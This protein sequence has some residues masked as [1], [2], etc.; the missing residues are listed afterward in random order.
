MQGRVRDRAPNDT[1]RN[2]F[3]VVPGR[4]VAASIS[5]TI[6]AGIVGVGFWTAI[7]M[8]LSYVSLLATGVETHADGLLLVGLLVVHVVALFAG[9]GYGR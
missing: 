5:R 3:A 2:A 6:K 1:V 7:L 8:P 9:H 4:G